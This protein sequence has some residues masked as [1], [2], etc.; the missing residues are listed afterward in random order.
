MARIVMHERDHPYAIKLDNGKEIHIC[1]CG[2]S[3]NKPYCDGTH[4]KTQDEEPGKIYLYDE[5]NNRVKIVSFY[6]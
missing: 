2:L 5:S 1:G 3:K 4:K 6:Y